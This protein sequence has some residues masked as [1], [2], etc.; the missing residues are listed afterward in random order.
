MADERTP[1]GRRILPHVEVLGDF[2][3][4]AEITR[5]TVTVAKIPGGEFHELN[6]QGPVLISELFKTAQMNV[7]QCQIQKN[8]EE[9][10]LDAYAEPGD[11]VYAFPKIRG[12]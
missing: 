9:V 10:G 11:E 3:L 1:D 6:I 4:P 2:P 5:G 12:N 8:G 7:E